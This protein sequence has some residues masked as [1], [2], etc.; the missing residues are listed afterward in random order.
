MS[1]LLNLHRLPH[2]CQK[3]EM[4]HL[5]E[6]IHMLMDEAQH[7]VEE[8]PQQS[9]KGSVKSVHRQRRR[10]CAEGESGAPGTDQTQGD[11]SSSTTADH[12]RAP[13]ADME[14]MEAPS[15]ISPACHTS[16]ESCL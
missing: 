9:D 7:K 13:V 5:K 15:I 16:M 1:A 14:D 3:C 4:E 12:A 8:P 10:R 2:W 11:V 6:E